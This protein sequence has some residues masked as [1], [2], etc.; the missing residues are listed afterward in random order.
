MVETK[1]R[2]GQNFKMGEARYIECLPA[3]GSEAEIYKVLRTR[4]GGGGASTESLWLSLQGGVR[5]LCKG[6]RAGFYE[7]LKAA[8]PCSDACVNVF[9]GRQLLAGSVVAT[10]GGRGRG[11][12]GGNG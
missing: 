6:Y 12:S 7:I 1:D 8:S 4:R 2:T 11:R 9:M 3:G 5:I 10:E